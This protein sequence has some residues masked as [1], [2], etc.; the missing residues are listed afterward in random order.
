MIAV[1]D[2]SAAIEIAINKTSGALLKE[3]LLK[4]DLVLA[5]DIFPSEITNAFWKYGTF[6]NL[7]ADKCE[8]GIAYCLDLIDDYINTKEL[9]FEALAESLRI[10]HPAY[11]LFYLVAAR[12]NNAVL[13]TRDKKLATIAKEMNILIKGISS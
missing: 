5:P 8:K 4:A 7:P 11:D 13:I 2:A 10:K 3:T 9:C 1:L 6:S 12:R